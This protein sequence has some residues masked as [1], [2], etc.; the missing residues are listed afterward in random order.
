[1]ATVTDEKHAEKSVNDYGIHT[2]A[3]PPK[4]AL[5]HDAIAPE[6]VGGIYTEMPPGYYRSLG[7]MGTVIVS[8]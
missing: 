6:A 7:F 8:T 5:H 3:P 1:M 2:H 4:I